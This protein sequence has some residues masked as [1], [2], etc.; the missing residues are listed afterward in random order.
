ML[1]AHSF[2]RGEEGRG[3]GAPVAVSGLLIVAF[4]VIIYHVIAPLS[5][6]NH[7]LPGSPE[8]SS[9]EESL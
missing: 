6:A 8:G 9:I 3:F 5:R 1:A 7:D 4:I 2:Q